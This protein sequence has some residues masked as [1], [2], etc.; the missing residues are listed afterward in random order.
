LQICYYDFNLW[1]RGWNPR[2]EQ[3][4]TLHCA[5]CHE[6]LPVMKHE[7]GQTEA[8]LADPEHLARFP[9]QTRAMMTRYQQ[10]VVDEPQTMHALFLGDAP[11]SLGEGPTARL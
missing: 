4:W 8:L 1:H 9:P 2:G 3:R 6:R 5:Y 11:P 7:H 10:R